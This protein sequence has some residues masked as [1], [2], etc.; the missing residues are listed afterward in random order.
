M[1]FNH[2]CIGGAA[3]ISKSLPE[4]HDLVDGLVTSFVSSGEF[5][6]DICQVLEEPAARLT[7][8]TWRDRDLPSLRR[9]ITRGRASAFFLVSAPRFEGDPRCMV[10]FQHFVGPN[11]EQM[12]DVTIRGSRGRL[13]PQFVVRYVKEL[14]TAFGATYG[15]VVS[16]PDI[17]VLSMQLSYM[18]VSEVRPGVRAAEL[19]QEERLAIEVAQY[20][21]LKYDLYA[22]IPRASWGNV[23]SAGHVAA[24]GG[25]DD[26]RATCGCYRVENWA[27]NLYLQLTESPWEYSNDQLVQLNRCLGPIRPSGAP[28]PVYL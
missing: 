3:H 4:C 14:V 11:D 5:R 6:P 17:T 9:D 15:C 12:A 7:Q 13:E 10:G 18:P 25:A 24:L 27:S 20:E 16:A 2:N 1:R 22:A 8:R 28:D 26:S 21:S 23:L 19:T